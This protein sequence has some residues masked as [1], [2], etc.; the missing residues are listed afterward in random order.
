MAIDTGTTC[1]SK[2]KADH[3]QELEHHG[4]EQ[5]RHANDQRGQ[6]ESR[7]VTPEQRV[8]YDG[9]RQ[10]Q[11]VL[12]HDEDVVEPADRRMRKRIPGEPEHQADGGD[13]PAG[14]GSPTAEPPRAPSLIVRM[15]ST[16]CPR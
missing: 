5:P 8:E 2:V 6:A 13:R 7:V 9:D 1:C 14:V 15:A 11:G 12:D 4:G 3:E 16:P 10:R